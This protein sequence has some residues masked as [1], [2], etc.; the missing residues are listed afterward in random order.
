MPQRTEKKTSGSVT[1]IR[2]QI[3][4]KM[5]RGVFVEFIKK[6]EDVLQ[7]LPETFSESIQQ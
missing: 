7:S 4:K 6:K 5:V 2:S 1:K 3:L